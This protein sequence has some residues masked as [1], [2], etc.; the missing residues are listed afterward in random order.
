MVRQGYMDGMGGGLFGVNGTM[1]RGQMVTILYRI[2][3][4]PSVEGL[5][6]PFRDVAE[7]RYYTD[8][9]IWAAANGIVEGMEEGVFAPEGAVTRQQVAVILYRHS[10]AEAGN[11]DLLSSYPDGKQVA[12]YA[13]QAMNWAVSQGLIRGVEN[14]GVTTL[15]PAATATRAQMATIFLR[16]LEQQG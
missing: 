12:P 4:K 9:V 14:G 10:G 11:E 15:S 7:G 6:N 2:A 13:R 1:T 16:Y 8:A 3:G 5:E